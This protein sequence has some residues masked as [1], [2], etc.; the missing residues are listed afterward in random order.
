MLIIGTLIY[1]DNPP[2]YTESGPT[3]LLFK[4]VEETGQLSDYELP[5]QVVSELDELDNI[6]SSLLNW[7]DPYEQLK[8]AYDLTKKI[9][10][11]VRIPTD[12]HWQKLAGE[13]LFIDDELFSLLE[14]EPNTQERREQLKQIQACMESDAMHIWVISVKVD[15]DQLLGFAHYRKNLPSEYAYLS[16]AKAVSV[17]DALWLLLGEQ[18]ESALMKYAHDDI[19]MLL[20]A[21]YNSYRGP[22]IHILKE[23]SPNLEH[24]IYSGAALLRLFNTVAYGRNPGDDLEMRDANPCIYRP[25]NDYSGLTQGLLK[26][27]FVDTLLYRPDENDDMLS[28]YIEESF[29]EEYDAYPIRLPKRARRDDTNST[30]L[31]KPPPLYRSWYE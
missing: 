2:S 25:G 3:T 19:A 1:S 26:R 7:V 31:S 9:E 20:K 15:G 10:K 6:V 8:Y 12:P 11:R 17:E 23:I 21:I 14:S 27:P 24:H 30:G 16:Q 22:F 29:D 18:N 5:I 4:T 13:E 28:D